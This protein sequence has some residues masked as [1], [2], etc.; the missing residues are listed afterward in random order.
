MLTLGID[1]D[2]LPFGTICLDSQ[3]NIIKINQHFRK[4]LIGGFH[5][6]YSVGNNLLTTETSELVITRIC[7]A[8]RIS[9]DQSVS[10][11]DNKYNFPLRTSNLIQNERMYTNVNII[12][13][14]EYIWLLIFDVTNEASSVIEQKKIEETLLRESHTDALTNLFNRKYVYKQISYFQDLSRRD[15]NDHLYGLIVIDL[16]HFKVINDTYGHSVG[17]EVLMKTGEVLL[18]TMRKTD[19]V[20]R[21]GGEEFLIFLPSS[22]GEKPVNLT[23]CCERI[24]HAIGNTVFIADGIE[25]SVTCSIGAV[26]DRISRD[27][28]SAF[29]RADRLMYKA[30]KNGRAQAYVEHSN[31]S[32]D[33]KEISALKMGAS[34]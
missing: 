25:F 28:N 29:R 32:N 11:I 1:C 2:S 30:K 21:I 31:L 34:T 8:L 19:I 17:D 23:R 9:C 5:E 15:N 4:H 18:A 27:V 10:W 3:L 7:D 16:D 14:D 6:Q 24:H 22:R 26:L 20:A 33:Q 13:Q 12:L